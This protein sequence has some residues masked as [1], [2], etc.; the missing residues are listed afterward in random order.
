MPP[1]LAAKGM[2]GQVV[3][4]KVLDELVALQAQT[5][6]GRPAKSYSNSW[7]EHGIKLEIPETGISLN[8]LDDWLREKLGHE[9]RLSGELVHGDD[10]IALTARK[11]MAARSASPARKRTSTRWWCNW[12]SRS[13]APPSPS[14]TPCI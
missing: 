1:D 11:A 8:E 2:T 10:G 9:S 4:A 14:A 5:S 3:A 7:G 12:P 13:T 6:S